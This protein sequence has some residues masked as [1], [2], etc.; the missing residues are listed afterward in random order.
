MRRHLG[1]WL[2]PSKG[3]YSAVGPHVDPPKTVP[4]NPGSGSRATQHKGKEKSMTTWYQ[5]FDGV[6]AAAQNPVDRFEKDRSG[7]GWTRID[8]LSVLAGKRVVAKDAVVIE[9]KDFAD[10]EVKEYTASGELSVIAE[11][12]GEIFADRDDLTVEEVDTLILGYLRLREE[13]EGRKKK[14]KDAQLT[15]L[16]TAVEKAAEELGMTGMELAREMFE[17]DTWT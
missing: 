1:K 11:H 17:G 4:K 7:S 8:D 9:R 12:G 15:T 5:R 10:L 16:F 2:A 6:I 13:L 3:G 14:E